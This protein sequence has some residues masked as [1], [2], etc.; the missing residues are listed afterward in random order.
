IN[1][2]ANAI[3]LSGKNYGARKYANNFTKEEI[4]DMITYAHLRHVLVFVTVNTLVFEEELEEL[5]I[6]TDY[7][8]KHHVDALI[9][10]DLGLI[11]YFVNRYP[12]T[13]IHASTQMNTYN[14]NQ[15]SYLKGLG[16]SRV[17]LARETS[18]DQIKVMKE[19]ID[20]DLEVF[21]HGALCVSYS[22]NCLFS[23]M[24]GGRSGNRG[25]CAQ[26]CR[27]AYRL[28]RNKSLIEP[29]SYLLSTKDLMTIDHLKEIALSGVKSFK[30]EG[31]MRRP[32]YVVATVRAYREA[33]DHMMDE[34]HEFDLERRI[35]ELL[36]SYNRDFTKGYLLN[37]LPSDINQSFRPN[38]LGIT[39][40]KVLNFERG[41]TTIILSDTL[42]KG[43]G[44]RIPGVKDIG[45][46]V[47]RILK[48]DMQ[49]ETA[50]AGDTIVID[51]ASAVLPGSIVM[52]TLDKA[53]DS[54][55]SPYF[56]ETY[57]LMDLDGTLK[58]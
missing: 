36:L 34:S 3:Y 38:H 48:N 26:P 29:E 44:I 55:L 52:K 15:L 47:G 28:F 40:G 43:D 10:Q 42:S 53:L 5:I 25:E 58:V 31:R 11:E 54:S 35:R 1:A 27:L 21:V 8:V 32:E 37:E 39:I 7:L 2:G 49:V 30:I 23:S 17:I 57:K 33:L 45:G 56:S 19:A 4:A 6:Y 18:I 50:D 41:K 14:S 13:E 46:E 12:D 51:L 20:I 22:G 24:N 16:V 9:V